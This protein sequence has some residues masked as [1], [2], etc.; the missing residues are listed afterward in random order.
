MTIQMNSIIALAMSTDAVLPFLGSRAGA[1]MRSGVVQ[2]SGTASLTIAAALVRVVTAWA[3][4]PWA[5][6]ATGSGIP[7]ARDLERSGVDLHRLVLVR[8][9]DAASA[10]Q[11]LDTLLR[12]AQFSALCIDLGEDASPN[13]QPAVVARFAHLCRRHRATVV[14]VTPG[15]R[16]VRAASVDLHLHTSWRTD[17]DGGQRIVIDIRRSRDAAQRGSVELDV[18]GPDGV[19]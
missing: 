19:C 17:D 6:I 3:V 4:R 10:L 5:W 12:S 15:D 16:I 8:A 11:P 1:R 18:Y 9:P 14:L 7:F 2:V 13:L